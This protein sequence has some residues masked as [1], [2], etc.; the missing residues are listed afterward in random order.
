MLLGQQVTCVTS[1]NS[2]RPFLL[3]PGILLLSCP[4]SALSLSPSV[5]GG[6]QHSS[7][8][9]RIVALAVDFLSLPDGQHKVF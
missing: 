4:P 1:V 3:L 8:F 7:A 2:L 5:A 6:P 9:D